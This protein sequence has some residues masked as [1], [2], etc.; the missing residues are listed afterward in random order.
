MSSKGLDGI[1]MDNGIASLQTRRSLQLRRPSMSDT[2]SPNSH[3]MGAFQEE[4][5]VGLYDLTEGDTTDEEDD[6]NLPTPKAHTHRNSHSFSS[7]SPRLQPKYGN[8]SAR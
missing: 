4:T 8:G 7:R 6:D 3:L 2:R 5:S 1:P